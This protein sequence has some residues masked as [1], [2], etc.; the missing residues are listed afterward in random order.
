M[1]N[2]I[3]PWS[4]LCLTSKIFSLTETNTDKKY[5]CSFV[6]VGKFVRVEI[7]APM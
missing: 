4:F 7:G 1:D 2:F 5:L 3:Y 6:S